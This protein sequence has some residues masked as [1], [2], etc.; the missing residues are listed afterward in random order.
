M[1][2]RVEYTGQVRSAAG[3]DRVEAECGPD[4]TLG[5]LFARLVADGPPALRPHLVTTDGRIQATLVVVV[6]GEAVAGSARET[7]PL[8]DGAAV[9]LLPPVA[10]G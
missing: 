3:R 4:A 6:D 2:V 10:G 9:V 8:R 1:T 5:D 7:T